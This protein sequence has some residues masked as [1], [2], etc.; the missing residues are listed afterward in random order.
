MTKTF[1]QLSCSIVSEGLTNWYCLRTT[2]HY[3]QYHHHIHS[4]SHSHYYYYDDEDYDDYLYYLPFACI[5]VTAVLLTHLTH[6]LIFPSFHITHILPQTNNLIIAMD[7]LT[8]VARS[9]GSHLSQPEY[10]R[11]IMP[12]VNALWKLPPGTYVYVSMMDMTGN[13]A[14]VFGLQFLDYAAEKFDIVDGHIA[15]NVAALAAMKFEQNTDAHECRDTIVAALDFITNLI[16][17][18]G[19]NIKELVASS[20][21]NLLDNI[22]T[23]MGDTDAQVLE[24]VMCL[25]GQL[26][27]TAYELLEPGMDTI[28]PLLISNVTVDR[29]RAR[30][31]INATW[32]L[33]EALKKMVD[34][35]APY[36]YDT[37][38]VLVRLLQMEYSDDDDI[39]LP[40]N[41]AMLFL[42]ITYAVPDSVAEVIDAVAGP[43]CQMATAIHAEE[44]FA[45]S[46]LGM[47][48]ALSKYP[49]A[50]A[51]TGV[52]KHLIL[53]AHTAIQQ[54]SE[55]NEDKLEALGEALHAIKNMMGPA[56]SK[57]IKSVEAGAAYN[58]INTFKL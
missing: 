26:I 11:T 13:L 1:S 22:V 46:L 51:E 30:P 24:S 23:L 6:F 21:H 58:V 55:G 15:Q 33:T 19:E 12:A 57:E 50:F 7:A 28:I 29:S 45:L 42:Y 34:G 10:V 5:A 53:F 20:R 35:F 41:C 43:V 39:I 3:Y 17:A 40:C 4:V 49:K 27:S 36:A 48:E 52:A 2:I 8:E 47:L 25:F 37:L 44:D 14:N 18:I 32:A 54:T 56:W 9:L 31:T 16:D 38:V